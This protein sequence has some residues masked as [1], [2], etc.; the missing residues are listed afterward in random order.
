MCKGTDVLILLLVPIIG[1][2]QNHARVLNDHFLK[3]GAKEDYRV[4]NLGLPGQM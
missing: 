2:M 4:K 3:R 1:G